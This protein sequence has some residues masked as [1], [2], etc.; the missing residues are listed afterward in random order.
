MSRSP[1]L[2]VADRRRLHPTA[3]RPGN[4]R[5]RPPALGAPV[6]PSQ[7]HP[8]PGSPG[9][10]SSACRARHASQPAEIPEGRPRPAKGHAPSATNALSGD[11]VGGLIGSNRKLRRCMG[12]RPR[13]TAGAFPIGCGTRPYHRQ[14]RPRVVRWSTSG[15]SDGDPR[16]PEARSIAPAGRRLRGC[17]EDDVPDR[18]WEILRIGHP[19]HCCIVPIRRAPGGSRT[20]SISPYAGSLPPLLPPAPPARL[21]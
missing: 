2:D 14:G 7:A 9:I 19:H 15:T 5:R 8:D 13:G 4:C 16:M 11:Q 1:R 12:G 10:P 21:R 17:W 18:G 6:R 3:P 20:P